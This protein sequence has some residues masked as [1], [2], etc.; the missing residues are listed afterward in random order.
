MKKGAIWQVLVG[1]TVLFCLGIQPGLAQQPSPPS[2]DEAAILKALEDH[3][4]AFQKKDLAGV[5]KFFAPEGD[6]VLM[7]IG[8]GEIYV[9]KEA[10]EN[11]YKQ[12]FK[13][14]ESETEK[15]GWTK[16]E[17]KGNMGWFMVTS[18][19]AAVCAPAGPAGGKRDFD[20]NLSG[21][22]EKRDGKWQCVAMHFSHVT[23]AECPVSKPATEKK[24]GAEKKPETKK[25]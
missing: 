10:I 12:F 19:V 18:D 20:M 4:A 11:A 23:G 25:K 9:G 15:F 17:V 1:L 8:G 22:M 3:E 2:P 13:G 24:P 16:I 7:G 5:M 6:T 21:V 14:F